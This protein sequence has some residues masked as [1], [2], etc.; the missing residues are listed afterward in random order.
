MMQGCINIPFD[1]FLPPSVGQVT[2]REGKDKNKIAIVD[3]SGPIT[4]GIGEESV[5][6]PV[7]DSVVDLANKLAVAQED[8]NVKALIVRVDSPGGG[9]TAS[10]VMYKQLKAFREDKKIPVYVSMVNLAASGGYYVSMAADKVYAHPT[11]VTGSIG[12][13]AT[14]PEASG[15]MNK[16]GLDFHAVTTGPYKDAGAFYREWTPQDRQY[17]Q[18]IVDDMFE[19]FLAVVREG[20]PGMEQDAIRKAADGRVY[21]AQQALELG[22]IDGI[23]YLDDVIAE[24]KKTVGGDPSVVLIARSRRNTVETAYAQTRAGDT[25][26]PR[27]QVNLLNVDLHKAF[28]VPQEPFQYIWVP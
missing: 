11:T 8:P 26:Q 10:D 9:V 6:N 19:R 21:T 3:I 16:I 22:L 2:Y 17:Y 15:L 1:A 5:F 27:T 28:V 24:A 12:V 4:M 25:A 13:I 23:L 7:T 20:R 14:F 18:V